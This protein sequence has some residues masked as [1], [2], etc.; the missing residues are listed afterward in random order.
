VDVDTRGS[1]DWEHAQT[2][3]DIMYWNTWYESP[4]PI[5][6]IAGISDPE[7]RWYDEQID[8]WC[9]AGMRQ[10]D[11]A[12]RL[13]YLQAVDRYITEEAFHLQFYNPR[14]QVLVKPWL[15]V[16]PFSWCGFGYWK[17]VIMEA[18]PE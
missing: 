10:L 8:K 18:H 12:E 9:Q 3:P 4:D 17:Y 14:H 1:L 2:F 5:L 7:S 16:F 11:P 13:K 15:Q 6:Y